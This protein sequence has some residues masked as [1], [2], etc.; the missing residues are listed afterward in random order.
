MKVIL[1]GVQPTGD[2]HLGN[3]LGAI[4]NWLP[5]QTQGE[6]L[7]CI[8]D[9]HALT[10]P[11]TEQ[12]LTEAVLYTAAAYLAAGI[13]PNNSHIFIQSRVAEHAQLQW[14]LACRT[15][16]GKLNR[17]TQFKEK[18][19]KDKNEAS[20]GLF[21][22]PVLMSADILL[23]RATHVPVGDDQSQHLELTREIAATINHQAGRQ[24]FPL[25]QAVA[26][27]AARVMSLRDG[28]VKMSK[29][30]PSEFSRIALTDSRGKIALKIQK[31]KTDP[32]PLPD[33]EKGL[34]GRPEAQ[35]LVKIYAAL[36]KTT[37]TA[38]LKQWGGSNF[39]KFK[40][41]LAECIIARLTP[42]GDKI[43][44]L[45]KDERAYI[46]KTLEDGRR[47]AAERAAVTMVS[48]Y[49]AMGLPQNLG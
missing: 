14:L 1:S 18:A 41:A 47:A 2:L 21:S 27:K 29:S 26:G 23:Y 48:V 11:Q 46:I 12:N 15:S 40:P 42:L 49:E 25:P 30:E 16:L 24:V 20:L 8:V 7:F 39:S 22:Y 13:D 5:L 34:E 10:V 17:M 19:P 6:A 4:E 45:L 43:N 35:N 28:T 31:A 44:L 33:E 9:L 36:E 32:N 38:V 3:Y 37:V